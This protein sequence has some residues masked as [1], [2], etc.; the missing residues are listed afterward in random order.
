MSTQHLAGYTFEGGFPTPETIQKAYNDADL[1]RAIQAYRFF[2]PAVSIAATWNGNVA[3]GVVPNRVFGILEGNP[4]Q[5][6]LTPNSDTPYAGILVDL[7]KGPIVVDVPPGPLMCVVNDLNQRYVMDLGVP[8]PDKGRGGLH[9]IVP[10]DYR[11]TLP[12]GYHVGRS[13]TFRALML[14]RAIP[15]RGDVDA[16]KDLMKRVKLRTLDASSEPVDMR[17]V[18]LTPLDA[19]FTAG[20]FE[21]TLE[22]WRVLHEIIDT[23]PALAEYHD[24]YGELAVLGIVKGK[25]FQPDHRMRVILERAAEVG[26]AQMR[27]Q[28]FADRRADRIMWTDRKWEWASLRPENGDFETPSHKDL[29]AREKWFFQAE[30]E[31]PAMFRRA[32]GAGSLYWLGL[33]DRSGAY[34]DGNK[35]YRLSIPLP[36]PAS[37]FWSVTVYDPLTRSEIQ[38]EQHRAAL[39]SQFELADE[40]GATAVDLYFSPTAP[41]GHE[42]RWI[43]TVPGRGWFCYFRIYGP[44]APAFDGNW[45]PGDFQIV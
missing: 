40:L 37:L 1:N 18:D 33:R 7:R 35:T 27:V 14:V 45:R 22:F 6:A 28:S 17:W 31:S 10:P 39:R 2:Y 41:A 13:S 19:N 25:Q 9:L 44:S 36:V 30:I 34:L 12:G 11:G 3:A 38:T 42:S 5:V 32:A 8:G 29:D 20:P 43:Q 24:Y 23:E 21:T 16:G 26:N 15:P 4:R